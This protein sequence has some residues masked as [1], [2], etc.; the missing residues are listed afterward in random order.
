MALVPPTSDLDP[1]FLVQGCFHKGL[2]VHVKDPS[3]RGKFQGTNVFPLE[4]VAPG[5]LKQ[6]AS[7]NIYSSHFSDDVRVT[8]SRP[9]PFLLIC[10]L[11]FY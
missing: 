10:R 9:A 2:I 5:H 3:I 6:Y 11:E 8:Y 7:G 1:E 4:I